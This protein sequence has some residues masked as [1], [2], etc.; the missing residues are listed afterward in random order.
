VE[1]V[2]P[3]LAEELQTPDL[4]LLDPPRAGLLPAA[5]KALQTLNSA[6]I[7]YVSCDPSTLARDLKHLCEAGYALQSVRAFD[8]FPQT[9]H[10]EAVAALTRD[11]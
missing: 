11:K 7:I 1:A 4:V 10:I 5:R 2:L 3:A 6:R 8:M 9:Y